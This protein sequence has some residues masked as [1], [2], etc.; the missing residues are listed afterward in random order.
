M[1]SKTEP[2]QRSFTEVNSCTVQSQGNL[3]KKA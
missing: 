3:R 2:R 1:R